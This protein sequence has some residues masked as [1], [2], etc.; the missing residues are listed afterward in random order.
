M[1]KFKTIVMAMVAV[2]GVATA[3]NAADY[4]APPPSTDVYSGFYLR[5]DA[6]W[7]FLNWKGGKDDNAVTVGG[8]VGYQ[9]S[10]NLR[11]D[12]RADYAGTYKIAPGADMRVT[13]VLGNMYFDIPTGMAITPYLGAGAGYGWGNVKGG[14][15][16]NGMAYALMAGAGIDVTQNMTL[17][18][19]YRFRS[20]MS[21]GD[22][23]MEHQVTA[24]VRFKF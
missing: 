6:G 21:S 17:D 19:G 2:A 24:G 14:S 3:A 23:P 7:S 22:N 10:Q 4:G 12:L 16:K 11:A 8:G 13:T 20:I 5:G 1:R 15:N 9:F 18:V